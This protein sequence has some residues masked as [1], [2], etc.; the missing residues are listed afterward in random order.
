[1]HLGHSWRRDTVQALCQ[2]PMVGF[3]LHPSDRELRTCWKPRPWS[4][5]LALSKDSAILI[6]SHKRPSIAT[7]SRCTMTIP[8]VR[9]GPFIFQK[10]CRFTGRP[11]KNTRLGGS[12][13]R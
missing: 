10:G 2:K 11:G 13:V 1:M 7:N 12:L 6:S 3:I 8:A 9:R 5:L 4:H